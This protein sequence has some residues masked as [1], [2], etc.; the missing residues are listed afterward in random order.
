MPACSLSRGRGADFPLLEMSR[1]AELNF[2]P[3]LGRSEAAAG[4][5]LKSRRGHSLQV[6]VNAMG[7]THLCGPDAPKPQHC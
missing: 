4:F 6:Q 3:R 1:A 2:E 7:R 5:E